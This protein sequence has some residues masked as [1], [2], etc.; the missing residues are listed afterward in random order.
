MALPSTN[1]RFWSKVQVTDTCWLWTASL[2]NSGYGRFKV[3]GKTVLAHRWIYEQTVGPI[4]EQLDH[5]C[6]VRHC[7]RPDH[8]DPVTN[9]ENTLR[10]YSVRTTCP[11]GH[12]HDKTN[13]RGHR[14]C[15]VCHRNAV[16]RNRQKV[17]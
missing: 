9:Q 15:S 8:L 5:L 14:I 4:P 6:K 3:D 2:T 10:A 16:R 17:A 12:V 11:Q 13:S 7:V 1:D